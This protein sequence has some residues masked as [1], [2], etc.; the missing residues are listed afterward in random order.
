MVSAKILRWSF[1]S[2]L[3]VLVYVALVA[4]F[5]S[6][7]KYIFGPAEPPGILPF[8]TLLLL[9][10]FS[11]A[12]TGTLVLGKPILLYLEGAKKE[13]VKLFGFTLGWIFVL[14]CLLVGGF[15]ALR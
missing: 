13:A 3:G 7:A 4:T 8:V 1:L 5:F 14:F 10:V 9:F 15:V 6:N 11:A 2:A 12:V